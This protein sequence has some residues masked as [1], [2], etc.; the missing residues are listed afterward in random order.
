M[1]SLCGIG[2]EISDR[3]VPS[4]RASRDI[5]LCRLQA[6]QEGEESVAE[7]GPVYVAA[8]SV[9]LQTDDICCK[10]SFRRSRQNY[11]VVDDTLH[12]GL[13]SPS[14]VADG[15]ESKLCRCRLAHFAVNTMPA[16][17]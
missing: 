11:S 16:C 9:N 7:S 10:R 15:N 14:M 13:L 3:G 4:T 6:V 8:H 12:S 2:S 5:V 17:Q 1:K